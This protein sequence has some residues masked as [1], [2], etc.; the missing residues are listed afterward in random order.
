MAIKYYGGNKIT[1]VSGDTKPTLTTDMKGATFFE[2]NTDD[3]YIWDGDSW[4]IVAGNTLIQDLSNKTFTDYL[5]VAERSAP[6]SSVGSGKGA[7]YVDS[8]GV[9]YGKFE[10]ATPVNLGVGAGA[11][12]LAALS[13]TTIGSLPSS[14]TTGH[15]LVY[16]NSNSWDNKLLAGVA[17]GGAGEC[18]IAITTAGLVGID[19]ITGL[20]NS[21][22]VLD[23]VSAGSVSIFPTLGTNT[24]SVGAT[25]ST[26]NILGNLTVSGVTTTVDT[27]NLLV[28]D[29]LIVI[30]KAQ[31]GTASVDSGFVVERGNDQ[32]VGLI[33]DESTNTFVFINTDEVGTTAGN[34]TIASYA[35]MKAAAIEGTVG[36]LTTS[37][38]TRGKLLI[39]TAAFN[40]T[41]GTDGH[42][43]HIDAQTLTD[44]TTS[45]SGTASANFSLVT[46]DQPTLAATNAST[47]TIAS[48][49]YIANAPAAGTNET[50]T[51]AYALYVA[52]GTVKIVGT[53]ETGGSSTL[54]SLIVTGDTD[55]QGDVNLGNATGDDI[56]I[57]GY[58]DT[59]II[60]K[61]DS[62]SDLGTAALQWRVAYIDTI[63]EAGDGAI[64]IEPRFTSGGFIADSTGREQM[65]FTTTSTAINEFTVANAAAD[66]SPTL[67]VTGGDTDIALTLKSKGADGIIVAGATANGAFLEFQQKASPG[68][69]SLEYARLYLKQVDAQNNALAVKLQ[70][71]NTIQE[72]EI[73]SPKAICGECG[74]TDGAKDP[75]Y[76]FSRSMM[77]V[78][79]WCGHAYEVPMTGWNMVS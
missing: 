37:L 2:T 28:E 64:L 58:V 23:V 18:V 13:D 39:D 17:A 11:S 72:V 1:G 7:F 14:G 21:G 54:A 57:I 49:V 45:A 74:S 62:T 56:S 44:N 76:D 46:I 40:I 31:T 48:T 52:A 22:T 30:S 9:F 10:N 65:I 75:T 53:L 36:L 24:L 77:L 8:N 59:S 12:T 20:A 63:G 34:V 32:N 6:G 33:W 42:L 78:E 5:L 73:T 43:F 27:T 69:P 67:S 15:I 47:T 79:L 3:L 4:N 35:P 55:L 60:P 50:L 51:N 29:P 71:A 16:D 61:T 19:S 26:V 25:A 66:G 38:E 70:K 68:D 41:L